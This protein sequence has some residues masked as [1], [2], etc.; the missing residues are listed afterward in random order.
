MRVLA[1]VLL[2]ACSSREPAPQKAP[3]PAAGGSYRDLV[4]SAQTGSAAERRD[5]LACSQGFLE[6]SKQ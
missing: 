1:L 3:E 4:A 6:L 5:A 2:G